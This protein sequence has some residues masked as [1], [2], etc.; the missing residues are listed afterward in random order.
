MLLPKQGQF[1]RALCTLHLH[2]LNQVDGSLIGYQNH[3]G[4][5]LKGM[6]HEVYITLILV[7]GNKNAK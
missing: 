4:A 6:Q 7:K 3:K 1:L 5:V 2:A